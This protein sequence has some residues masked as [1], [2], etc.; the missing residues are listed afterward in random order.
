MTA[1]DP[2]HQVHLTTLRLEPE[3][4]AAS[5]HMTRSSPQL[6]QNSKGLL[7]LTQN[8]EKYQVAFASAYVSYTTKS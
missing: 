5:M 6:H 3:S 2:V 4:L 8:D 1:K 7:L